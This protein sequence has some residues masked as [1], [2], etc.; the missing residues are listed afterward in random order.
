MANKEQPPTGSAKA[1]PSAPTKTRAENAADR[2]KAGH[3]T[4]MSIIRNMK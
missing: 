1:R 2:A 4:A 3:D